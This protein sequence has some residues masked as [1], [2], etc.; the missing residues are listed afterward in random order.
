MIT[1][2]LFVMALA[3]LTCLTPT[4]AH[5]N[6]PERAQALF[7]EAKRLHEDGRTREALQ[8]LK[9]AYEAFPAEGILVSI[10]NRHMDL[11]EPEE[12][13][14][15]LARISGDD[16]NIKRAADQLREKVAEQLAQPVSLQ[17]SAD[18]PEATV[19]VDG[20]PRRRLPATL[21]LARGAHTFNVEAPGRE[22]VEVERILKGM[23]QMELAVTL[24]IPVGRWRLG[25]EP[26]EPIGEVRIVVEGK[27]VALSAQ[28]RTQL[29]TTER[30]LAPGNYK[31]QCLRGIDELATTTIRVRS[32]EVV[33]GVCAF[34]PPVEEA[35][36]N[37]VLGWA[38]AGGAV[39]SV[40][41]GTYFLVSYLDEK[42]EFPEP[43]YQIEST[44]PIGAGVAYTTGVG[45]GVLSY[46]FF[47]GT[48]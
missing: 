1:R 14:E 4:D 47:S 23:A 30:E 42:E 45:L 7:A 33:T 18:A 31:I 15:T 41:V 29:M 32:D 38:T 10:A 13:Q 24:P 22:A 35:K 17:V 6:D 12:A 27:Q 19:S 21:L 44:K 46:L 11:G 5:A 9:E 34:R 26:R 25:L 39:V 3:L 2:A 16:R 36:G 40:A 37:E 8:R 43:R 20:G 28:E 48:L